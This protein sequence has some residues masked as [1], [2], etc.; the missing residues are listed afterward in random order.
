[1]A[2]TNSRGKQKSKKSKDNTQQNT[3]DFEQEIQDLTAT[4][5][6]LEAEKD[7]METKMKK[8]LA[9]YMNLEKNIDKRIELRLDEM[10]LKVAR[11]L[12]DIMDDLYYGMETGKEFNA[13]ECVTAWMEG[14]RNSYEKMQ[15]TLEVL[16]VEI[17]EVNVGDNFDSSTHEAIGT[18]SEGKNGT[19]HEVVQ[20]GYIMG[21]NVVRPARVVVSQ[22]NK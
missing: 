17:I 11:Y 12:L 19:I 5:E 9:D 2:K 18:V 14:I 3:V 21:E 20:P 16:G 10:K 22:N 15:K 1:M 8:A 6:K 13:D 7:G 4:V